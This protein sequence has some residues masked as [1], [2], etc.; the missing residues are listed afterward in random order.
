MEVQLTCAVG[1]H[2]AQHAKVLALGVCYVQCG[3]VRDEQVAGVDPERGEIDGCVQVVVG[4][5]HEF[6]PRAGLVEV[7]RALL[8]AGKRGVRW[9]EGRFPDMAELIQ[10]IRHSSL[11]RIIIHEN[12]DSRVRE[13]HLGKCGPLVAVLW[14]VCGF[15][16]VL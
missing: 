5:I 6:L 3:C 10:D 16:D 14:N 8:R 9:R 12:D 15:V 11:V 1:G 4:H 13:D 7:R 2:K